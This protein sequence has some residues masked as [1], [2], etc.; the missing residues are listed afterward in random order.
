MYN[1]MAIVL[2]LLASFV[3]KRY[4]NNTTDLLVAYYILVGY[5]ILKLMLEI[6]TL[7]R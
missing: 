5:L 4:G 6:L 3:V 1:I 2:I 7:L